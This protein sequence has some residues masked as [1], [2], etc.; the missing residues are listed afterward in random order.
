MHA[1]TISVLGRHHFNDC[2]SLFNNQIIGEL[3]FGSRRVIKS[4]EGARK[5]FKEVHSSQIGGHS[6]ILKT[7]TAINSRFYWLGMFIDIY[8][9]VYVSVI[10]CFKLLLGTANI[11]S[12]FPK[13]LGMQWMPEG[14]KTFGCSTGIRVYINVNLQSL[15]VL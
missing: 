11:K 3:F 7:C 2:S 10:L 4:K 8:N 5:L 1:H 15:V 6:G 12:W 9:W 13:G 14:W